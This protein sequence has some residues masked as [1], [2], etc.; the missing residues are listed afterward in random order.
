VL[1]AGAS[2]WVFERQAA[3]PFA[4]AAPFPLNHLVDCLESGRKPV[5]SIEDARRS[6]IVAMAAYESAREKRPVDLKW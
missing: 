3:E 4:P 1:A 2:D 6:F 5:A